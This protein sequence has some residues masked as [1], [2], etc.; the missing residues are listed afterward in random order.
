MGVSSTI[1]GSKETW[2][3]V[4]ENDAIVVP[5]LSLRKFF[6]DMVQ[7]GNPRRISMKKSPNRF[8]FDFFKTPFDISWMTF[9]RPATYKS[10]I[11]A[12]G[13]DLQVL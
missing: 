10:N 11:D 12:V 3:D 7:Q 8:K 4:F 2:T 6:P 1:A 13:S 9:I 5:F